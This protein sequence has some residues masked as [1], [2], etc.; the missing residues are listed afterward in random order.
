LIFV[1][2]DEVCTI[3]GIPDDAL[4]RTQVEIRGHDQPMIVR[5]EKDPT[6]LKPARSCLRP[7]RR[8][9]GY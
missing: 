1:V 5:T 4:L 7:L 6:V 9:V 8:F 3:A 2:S